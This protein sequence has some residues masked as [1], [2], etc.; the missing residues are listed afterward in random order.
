MVGG[1]TVQKHKFWSAFGIWNEQVTQFS[2]W[3][4]WQKPIQLS[5]PDAVMLVGSALHPAVGWQSQHPPQSMGTF[6]LLPWG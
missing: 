3:H 6:V 5:N 4:S 2:G 1:A